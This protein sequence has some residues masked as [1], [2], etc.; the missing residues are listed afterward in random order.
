MRLSF[1][2]SLLWTLPFLSALAG[3]MLVRS[4]LYQH[5]IITPNV[6]G[7]PL[8]QACKNLS[9]Q[10]INLQIVRYKNDA[11]IPHHTVISQTPYPGEKMR[12]H[13][14]VFLTVSQ[15]PEGIKVPD[16]REKKLPDI[17]QTMSSLGIRTYTYPIGIKYPINSCVAHYPSAGTYLKHN[18]LI[19]Y[20]SGAS[21]EAVI[22][23]NFVGKNIVVVQDFLK[24]YQINPSITYQ[25]RSHYTQDTGTVVDQR[26]LAASLIQFNPSK[27]PIVQLKVIE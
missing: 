1:F 23:P 11:D 22:W 7:M 8:E 19:I 6:I 9:D 10:A 20:H 3:Y 12:Q 16:F 5:A 26:P 18:Y 21:Q 4:M 24:K 17:E 13:Q 15:E 2:L 27:P 14:T 25:R